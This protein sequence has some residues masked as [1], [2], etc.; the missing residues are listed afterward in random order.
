M[1]AALYASLA[2]LGLA[3]HTP[4]LAA[5]GDADSA[6]D[7]DGFAISSLG[8]DGDADGA[9]GAELAVGPDGKVVLAVD[10]A[11]L[12]TC[13]DSTCAEL[14]PALAR[15]NPDGSLDSSF[16]GDGQLEDTAMPQSEDWAGVEIEDLAVQPDG[17]IVLAGSSAGASY[18]WVARLLENGSPDPSFG[19]GDGAVR[20]KLL[21]GVGS[22]SDRAEAVALM[23]DGR[24]VVGGRSDADPPQHP[25]LAV[26]RLLADGSLD[27]SFSDDGWLV[28]SHQYDY[29]ELVGVAIDP[30]GRIVAA[31]KPFVPGINVFR[32]APGGNRDPAFSDDGVAV[33][34][35]YVEASDMALDPQGRTVLL[36]Q[37]EFGEYEPELIRVT[38]SGALDPAFA[39]DGTVA[40]E[41]VEVVD[42]ATPTP[43]SEMDVDPQSRPVVGA[44]YGPTLV[45]RYTASGEIDA[46]FSADGWAPLFVRK[47]TARASDL[48][49]TSTGII[50]AGTVGRREEGYRPVLS[51]RQLTEGPLDSDGDGSVDGTEPCPLVF[52]KCPRLA[53]RMSRLTYEVRRDQLA[54]RAHLVGHTADCRTGDVRVLRVR[55]GPD[56]RIALSRDVLR[57]KVKGRFSR[58]RFYATAA[59]EIFPHGKCPK[60]RS[61]LLRL[62]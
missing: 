14:F 20:V 60:V 13:F 29:S 53:R 38:S 25:H 62:R 51:R 16:A 39:G 55:P 11:Y 1:A 56:R 36:G 37:N 61:S 33:V 41:P 26:L 32:Y 3:A 12:Y 19:G 44:L 50:L 57:I 15:F 52:G 45:G 4:A 18:I 54:M 7:E 42:L 58:G 5:P 23:D 24:I 9:R 10:V 27:P 2:A 46:G 40:V 17:S 34:E 43:I 48:A 22:S 47:N 8:R 59:P 30:L 35:G 28:E 49:A 6:F 21:G 31:G